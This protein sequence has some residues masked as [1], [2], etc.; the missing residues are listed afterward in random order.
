M[1]PRVLEEYQRKKQQMERKD[2]FQAPQYEYDTH[3][4]E[5]ILEEAAEYGNSMNTRQGEQN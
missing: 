4:F 1:D 5:Q 2:N 3:Q